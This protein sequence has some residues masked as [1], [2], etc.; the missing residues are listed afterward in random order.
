MEIYYVLHKYKVVDMFLNIQD[1]EDYI[2]SRIEND[3]T[4]CFC[5]FKIVKE[6]K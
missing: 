3:D 6:I 5:D 2:I 1:C 4:L